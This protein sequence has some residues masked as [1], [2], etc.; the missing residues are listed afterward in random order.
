MPIPSETL[1]KTSTGPA[2]A[3]KAASGGDAPRPLGELGRDERRTV[4]EFFRE[5]VRTWLAFWHD[6]PNRDTLRIL[7]NRAR[8]D[9]HA[10]HKPAPTW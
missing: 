2:R 6:M 3:R 8:Y 5:Q 4:S 1:P 7:W 9:A 10:T